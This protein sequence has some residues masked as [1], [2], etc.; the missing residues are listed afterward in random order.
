[1]VA[2]SPRLLRRCHLWPGGPEQAN[3][4]S[5]SRVSGPCPDPLQSQTIADLAEIQCG[6][7][8]RLHVDPDVQPRFFKARPVL[9]ALQLKIEKELDKLEEEG[10]IVPVQHSKW[11][12]QRAAFKEVKKLLQLSNLLAHLDPQVVLACDTSLYGLGA[13]LSHVMEDSTGKTTFASH[14]YLCRKGGT[15]SWKKRT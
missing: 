1:M 14:T 4:S 13:V 7:V 6:V 10:V 5:L 3:G 8:A 9:Y 11:V 2:Y 15:L 12:A